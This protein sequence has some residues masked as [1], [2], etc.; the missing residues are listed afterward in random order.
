MQTALKTAPV[1]HY[2]KESVTVKIVV[3]SSLVI[4]N[5]GG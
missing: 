3:T 2:R 4:E 5:H 1:A